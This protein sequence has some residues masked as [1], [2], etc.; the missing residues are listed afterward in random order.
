MDRSSSVPEMSLFHISV[1][2]PVY[3]SFFEDKVQRVY[4]TVQN[5]QNSYGGPASVT[6]AVMDNSGVL[7]LTFNREIVYPQVL[8]D[9]FDASFE[10]QVPDMIVTAEIEAAIK[11]DFGII[12]S[13]FD[14]F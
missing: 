10:E 7:S 12:M 8:V 13:T 5:W 11:R 2:K 14:A 1:E 6:D 4:S 3:D 9:D